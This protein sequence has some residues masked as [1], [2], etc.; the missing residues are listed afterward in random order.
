MARDEE[1]SFAATLHIRDHCL[2]LHAQRAARTMARRFDEAFRRFDLTNGQFSLLV[3][4]NRPAPTRMNAVAEL[5]GM[6]RTTLTAA[7]K[8]LQ[9][10]GLIKVGTDSDDRRGRVLTLTKIGRALVSAVV[11]VWR[12][13]HAEVERSLGRISPDLMRRDLR[14]LSA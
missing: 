11:P 12:R 1:I 9:R 3:A 8:P 7:L 14:T 5:L 13:T 10:R 6:D 2:C 4:L